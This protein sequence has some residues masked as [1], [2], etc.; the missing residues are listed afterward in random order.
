[1]NEQYCKVNAQPPYLLSRRLIGGGEQLR[2]GRLMQGMPHVFLR[3]LV[4]KEG[5]KFGSIDR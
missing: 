4:W 1:M 2:V 5:R 3:K